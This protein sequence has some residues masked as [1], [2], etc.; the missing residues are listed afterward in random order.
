MAESPADD[1][2]GDEARP[3]EEAELGAA[4]DDAMDSEIRRQKARFVQHILG[5]DRIE[6]VGRRDERWD[7]GF[8][9]RDQDPPAR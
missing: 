4:V 9:D 1:S 2:S 8:H 6:G 3:S 7:E 5:L